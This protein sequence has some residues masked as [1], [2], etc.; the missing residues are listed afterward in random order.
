MRRAGLRRAGLLDLDEAV[1]QRIFLDLDLVDLLILRETAPSLRRAVDAAEPQWERFVN[2]FELKESQAS[3]RCYSGPSWRKRFEARSAASGC[4]VHLM[5][6]LFTTCRREGNCGAASCAGIASARQLAAR[7]PPST[8]R[9][10]RS[11]SSMRR[12]VMN[13]M[14][15]T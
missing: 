9:M 6:S 14:L 7:S 4:F 15:L 2:A 3:T 8:W 5:C 10:H 1:L 12:R 13:C 11:R